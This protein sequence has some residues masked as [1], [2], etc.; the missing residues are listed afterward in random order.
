MGRVFSFLVGPSGKTSSMRVMASGV[1]FLVMTTWAWVSI[2]KEVLQPMDP[3][4][5]ALVLGAMG[6]Q[7]AH[8]KLEDPKGKKD[9]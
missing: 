9:E 4:H 3:E 8:K 5:M 1:V 2:R 6:I 7:T